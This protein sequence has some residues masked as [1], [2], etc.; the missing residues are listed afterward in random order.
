MIIETD[1]NNL[2]LKGVKCLSLPLTLDC[3]EAFRWEEQPDGSWSGA[4]FGK[5]LNIKE[6]NGDFILKDTSKEDFDS[7]WF[8]Y[9]DL[10]RDYAAICGKLKEDPLLAETI[11]EYYGIRILNQ[12]PWE[13]L[14]SFIISQQN[15]I[16]RIKGI[17]KRLCNA[18]GEKI[19][20]EWHSFPSAEK[21]SSLSVSDFEKIGAGYR[22]KYIKR[23]ADDVA[24]GNID[25]AQIKSMDL[26]DAKKA[27]LNIYGVGIKVA[28]CALLFGFQFV[29]CF[30]VDVW[31]KRV[32][33]FYPDGLP[34]CFKGY[35]GIAQQY[36]FHWARN[37]LN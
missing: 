1:K 16:K 12:D 25:L 5:F 21:L 36:L 19:N 32:L 8:N 6:E 35:E 9:F 28:N 14:V 24:G 15:N 30:P 20:D 27:L 3:G 34:Q 13:A 37:N 26:E 29:E 7:V 10:N 4:A 33:E 31:M 23:L 2:I 17:I 18:Y 11:D 22:A